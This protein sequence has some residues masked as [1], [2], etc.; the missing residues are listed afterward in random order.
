MKSDNLQVIYNPPP[1]KKKYFSIF[2][3]F[4]LE[5]AIVGTA[6]YFSFHPLENHEAWLKEMSDLLT[7]FD[8]P[9]H[10]RVLVI[11][12]SATS[13]VCET[14]NYEPAKS[15]EWMYVHIWSEN[16][17]GRTLTR[18]SVRRKSDIK[19]TLKDVRSEGEDSCCSRLGTAA[20]SCHFWRF[21]WKFIQ[22]FLQY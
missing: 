3:A 6:S 17:M 10:W 13:W 9:V 20:S 14:A 12:L 7:N 1:P 22:H 21:Q 4:F 2:S 8:I 11:I 16:L 18:T 19:I 5:G 15:E